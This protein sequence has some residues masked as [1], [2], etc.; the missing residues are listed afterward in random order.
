MKKE[1]KAAARR[2]ASMLSEYDFSGGV[3]GKYR[4]RWAA[5]SNIVVLSP[6]VACVFRDSDSVNRALRTLLRIARQPKKTPS[7]TP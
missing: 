2:H 7:R 5:G 4:N 6:D 3:R 1:S